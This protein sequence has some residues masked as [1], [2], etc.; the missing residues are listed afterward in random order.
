MDFYGRPTHSHAH[1]AGATVLI[2][3]KC[4]TEKVENARAGYRAWRAWEERVVCGVRMVGRW[5]IFALLLQPHWVLVE[6]G[7]VPPARLSCQP[8]ALEGLSVGD[9]F[10]AAGGAAEHSQD[11]GRA[12]RDAK[13][14]RLL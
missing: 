10:L 1:Q 13:M 4:T 2:A 7:Q 3:D 12:C 14:V 6:P 11:T 9:P 8:P 5:L